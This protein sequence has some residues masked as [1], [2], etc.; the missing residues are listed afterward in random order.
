MSSIQRQQNQPLH[1]TNTPRKTESIR[2]AKTLIGFLSSI[3][4]VSSY[5]KYDPKITNL[6]T[7]FFG[8]TD[9]SFNREKKFCLKN[10]FVFLAYIHSTYQ[11]LQTNQDDITACQTVEIGSN[12]LGFALAAKTLR[13]I[14]QHCTGYFSPIDNENFRALMQKLSDIYPF[15]SSTITPL[16]EK[17]WSYPINIISVLLLLKA[18]PSSYK[19][20]KEIEKKLPEGFDFNNTQHREFLRDNLVGILAASGASLAEIISLSQLVGLLQQIKGSRKSLNLT[21]ILTQNLANFETA[22]KT[23]C[24][25]LPLLVAGLIFSMNNR[26]RGLKITSASTILHTIHHL[27]TGI[28][29]Y[30]IPMALMNDKIS[31]H[32]ILPHLLM[33]ATYFMTGSN[34]TKSTNKTSREQQVK[35]F[36]VTRALPSLGYAMLM[37]HMGK[38]REANL[39]RAALYVGLI[40]GSEFIKKNLV[41]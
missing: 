11:T 4:I 27:K 41:G 6:S 34:S 30:A 23:N 17:C 37:T 5:V 2:K 22:A 29:S 36:I 26:Q 18:F 38:G 16:Q 9:V 20:M 21:M 35:H 19:I 39:K 25:V 28:R 3:G 15:P 14:N 13:G 33:A 40:L 31:N 24:L 12:M 10:I 32:K 8:T 7:Q 1:Q